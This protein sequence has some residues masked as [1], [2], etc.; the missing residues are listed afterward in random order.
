MAT[1]DMGTVLVTKMAR[2]LTATVDLER[3]G[4]VPAIK[5]RSKIGDVTTAETVEILSRCP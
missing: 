4:S 2:T 5:R 1:V 3:A